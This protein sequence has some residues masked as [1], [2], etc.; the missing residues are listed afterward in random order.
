MCRVAHL[1]MGSTLIRL[2][3]S[4]LWL[5]RW[6]AV[7]YFS[8]SKFKITESYKEQQTGAKFGKEYKAVYW[9]PT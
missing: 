1:R 6:N 7:F 4:I 8:V 9:H 5:K 3:R 2:S